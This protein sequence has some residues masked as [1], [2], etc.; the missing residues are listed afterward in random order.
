MFIVFGEKTVTRKMGFV[1]EGCPSCQ[2]VQPV[3]IHRLGMAPHIF[4]VPLGRGRLIDYFGVCQKC[5]GELNIFPTDYETLVRKPGDDLVHLAQQTNPKLD[6]KNRNAIEAFERFRRV[7]DPLLRANKTLMDRSARGTRF[8]RTSGLT[9]LAAVVIPIVMFSVDLTSLSYALQEFIGVAAIWTFILGLIAT[10]VLV[11]REPRR[12]F[13]R[14]LE[15]GIARDLLAVNPR[16]DELD[17]YLKR[18]KKFEYRVSEHVSARRLMD[19][20]QLQQLDFQ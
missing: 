12:F 4:W 7:R 17:D 14:E 15:P 13:R 11:A 1:A 6:P 10:F 20:M 3:R 16:P 9:L 2:A 8:D 18:I 5:G 19:Q